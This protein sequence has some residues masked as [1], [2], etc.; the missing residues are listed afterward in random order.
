VC[1]AEAI[2]HV[3]TDASLPDPVCGAIEEAGIEVMRA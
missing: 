1:E 2:D 3:V